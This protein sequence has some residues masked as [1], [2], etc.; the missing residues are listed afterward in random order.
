MSDTEIARAEFGVAG[1]GRRSIVRGEGAYLWDATGARYV[2]LGAS[3][4]VANLGHSHPRLVE[5]MRRQVSELVYVGSG[6]T[7]PAR[8]EFVDRLLSLLPSSLGRVF[9]SNSGTEAM[10][11]A[12]KIAR[13]S[14][15]RSK[16]VAM[17]R[18]FHGR[19]MGA[20]STT[21]RPELRK[22]FEPLLPGVTHVPFNDV[23]RLEEAVD[24]TT[25]AV[26][27]E[28]VQGE[29]GVHPATV[30]FLRAAR[31]V[32]DRTGALLVLDE[33]QTGMGRT[34]RRW[35]FEHAGI[36]PDLLALAKSLA[37]GVPIGATVCSTAVERSFQGTL[38]STFGGNPLACAAGVAA[39]D[40]LVDE[41][42]DERAARLGAAGLERLRA[43]DA[44]RI[45]EVRGLGLM[46][47]IEL[48]ERAIPFLER[49]RARG[50]LASAA[51]PEVIRLLPPLV[52][53][54]ADWGAGL[55]ALAEV[56]CDAG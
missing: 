7:T 15:G 22:P 44:P 41:R 50:Y 16:F 43:I 5:A 36:V 28:V 25:D 13:S 8:I 2:D 32:C 33:V 46:I 21:W 38:H 20:L 42:L 51:G 30:E 18:G 55:D 56:L 47:G 52:I 31:A 24:P 6:Y 11:N 4:G 48:K 10:E 14:T 53:G 1:V 54:E 39:L 23:A 12:L 35:A 45:R 19:T 27:L 3:L 26:I 34:G 9:L 40:I 29:G 17:M 37:G 49:L